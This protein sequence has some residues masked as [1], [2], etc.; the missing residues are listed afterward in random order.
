[1]IY[2]KSFF[3]KLYLISKGAKIGKKFKCYIFPKVEIID[4]FKLNLIL[5]ENVIISGKIE[6]KQRGNSFLKIGNNTKI[7]QGVRIIVANESCLNISSNSK[8]MFYSQINCGAN[9]SIGSYT[10]VSAFGFITSSLHNHIIEKNYMSTEYT[11]KEIIIGNNVQ[12]GTSCYVSPGS[13][14]EDNLVIAPYSYVSGV[15]KSGYVYQGFPIK[16][17]SLLYKND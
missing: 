4:S 10:G 16:K 3:I 14:I 9:V 15:L 5:G 8:I 11:H 1:M 6:I 2:I 17:V 12:I 13:V 7:D